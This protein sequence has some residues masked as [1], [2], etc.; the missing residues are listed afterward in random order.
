MADALV[1][2]DKVEVRARFDER[3]VTGF[4]VAAIDDDGVHLKRLSDGEQLPVAFE[5]AD[6]R[7]EHKATNMWWI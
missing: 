6:V 7:P 5:Q 4:E 3:W 2:G 1:V